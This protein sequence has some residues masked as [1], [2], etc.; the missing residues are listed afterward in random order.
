MAIVD[1][2]VL[3]SVGLSCLFGA[4][5][6]LVKEALSLSFWIG[7]VVLASM[8][9]DQASVFL[10]RV[11]DNAA[12]RRIVAFV[13]I[14]IVTVFAGGLISNLISKLTSA[15]GLGSVDRAL[16]ALFGIIRGVVIVTVVVVLTLQLEFTREVYGESIL[17]PYI[18]VLGEFFQNLLG[19]TPASASSPMQ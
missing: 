13:L 14:F 4:F 5:R 6:G 15:A 16:G 1:I 7:A 18:M 11:N 2:I 3:G 8:F 17:V 12:L 10:E 19:L 9:S